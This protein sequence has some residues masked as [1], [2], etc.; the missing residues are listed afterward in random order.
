MLVTVI[1]SHSP[2]VSPEYIILP[3]GGTSESA[4]SWTVP[5]WHP[6]IANL[7]PRDAVPDKSSAGL[8]CILQPSE[9]TL[10]YVK[11]GYSQENWPLVATSPNH[12]VDD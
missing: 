1:D 5:Y 4:L 7:G 8:H 10:L 2:P 12:A 3:L 6:L 11:F 9:Y